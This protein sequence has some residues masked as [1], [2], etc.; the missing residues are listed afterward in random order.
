MFRLTRDIRSRVPCW[1]SQR[2]R[3]ARVRPSTPTSAASPADLLS[4]PKPGVRRA[5]ILTLAAGGP[6]AGHDAALLV[7]LTLEPDNLARIRIVRALAARGCQSA[8]PALWG[9]YA[10]AAT[11][12]ELAHAAILAHDRLAAAAEPEPRGWA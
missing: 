12:V 5:A 11:P 8:R 4:H 3:S 9:L 2:R 6:D 7:R 1:C 10:D